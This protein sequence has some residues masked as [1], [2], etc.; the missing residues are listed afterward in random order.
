MILLRVFSE[1]CRLFFEDLFPPPPSDSSMNSSPVPQ[2]DGKEPTLR[3]VKINKLFTDNSVIRPLSQMVPRE[4]QLRRR[5]G[6]IN[7]E[8][9]TQNFSNSASNMNPKSLLELSIL[10]F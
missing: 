5:R 4:L 1:S 2:E 9:W 10:F 8:L 7:I 6:A 3:Y